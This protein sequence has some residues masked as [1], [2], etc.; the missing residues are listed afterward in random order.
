[1][2]GRGARIAPHSPDDPEAAEARAEEQR[3]RIESGRARQGWIVL[4]T[5]LRRAVFLAGLAGIVI[6]GI[7]LVLTR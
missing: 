4:R 2:A 5:P 7:A 6:L 1:M 3:E